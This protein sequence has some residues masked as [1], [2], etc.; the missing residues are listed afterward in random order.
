MD[1]FSTDVSVIPKDP[2]AR[3]MLTRAEST[4]SRKGFSMQRTMHA[5]DAVVTGAA[6]V[7]ELEEESDLSAAAA[8]A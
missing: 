2:G 7:A 3:P 1:T 8:Y 5:D 6:I 4:P